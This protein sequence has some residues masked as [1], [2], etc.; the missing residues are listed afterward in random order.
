MGTTMSTESIQTRSIQSAS[1]TVGPFFHD[2]LIRGGENMMVNDQTRGT[3]IW[4]RGHVLDGDG[5]AVPDAMLEIWQA[6][7]TGRFNHASDS[8]R[9]LADQNFFGFGRSPTDTNGAYWFRTIKPGPRDGPPYI[10]VRLFMRGLLIHLVTRIYFSDEP[11]DVVLESLEPER[12]GT[13]IATRENGAEG[14]TYRFDIHLQGNLET[15]FF[16]V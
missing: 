16:D 6:D 5:Q 4:L 15:V 13:L 1:Q 14:L 10:N 2:A 7:S 9:A 8:E 12:R 11:N 3:R